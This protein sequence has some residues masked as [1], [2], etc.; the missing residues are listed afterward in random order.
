MKYLLIDGFIGSVVQF[1]G[2]LSMNIDVIH[3]RVFDFP[4]KKWNQNPHWMEW[5]SKHFDAM[6]DNRFSDLFVVS[7]DSFIRIIVYTRSDW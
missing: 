5:M 1:F 6:D 2:F 7:F 3:V 4:F